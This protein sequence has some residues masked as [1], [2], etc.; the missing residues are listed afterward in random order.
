MNAKQNLIE[1]IQAEHGEIKNIK[2][3]QIFDTAPCKRCNETGEHSF[4][5]THGRK[6]FDCN[7]KTWVFTARGKRQL[8]KYKSLL[9]TDFSNK[10]EA[11]IEGLIAQ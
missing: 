2:P 8:D 11:L 3:R 1:T 9:K 7:G 5:I 4:H 6:C 10:T